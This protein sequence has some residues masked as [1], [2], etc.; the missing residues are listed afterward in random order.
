[1][2]GDLQLCQPVRRVLT[3]LMDL[4]VLPG[5][6]IPAATV[7]R[8]LVHQLILAGQSQ[9]EPCLSPMGETQLPPLADSA[10][11]SFTSLAGLGAQRQQPLPQK[12]VEQLV[13][14]STVLAEYQDV[15]SSAHGV[16]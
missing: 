12:A 5:H 7:S 13:A 10:L 14:G 2:Q 6:R 1:M 3:F 4:Q 11:N 8:Q 9:T 15:R 16:A